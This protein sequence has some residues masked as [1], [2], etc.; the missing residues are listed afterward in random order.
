MSLVPDQPSDNG[1][2]VFKEPWEAQALSLVVVLYESG[3]FS[4]DEWS[5]ALSQ[6]IH[7]GL[8]PGG[9]NDDVE[10]VGE[11]P[12][13]RMG[14]KEERGDSYYQHWLV[15]LEH[16]AIAKGL[17]EAGELAQRVQAWREAY[18]ATPHGQPVELANG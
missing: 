5:E 17:A 1:E 12:G 9:V 3:V 4:W 16:L 2:L 18:L 11:G 8:H 7:R 6:A 10:R 14:E 15:A 13:E